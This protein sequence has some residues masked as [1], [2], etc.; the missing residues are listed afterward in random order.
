MGVL[1]PALQTGESIRTALAWGMRW[2]SPYVW[3][4]GVPSYVPGLE[5]TK[6]CYRF[7]CTIS[8]NAFEGE[9]LGTFMAGMVML[10]PVRGFTPLRGFKSRTLKVPKSDIRMRPFFAPSA[11]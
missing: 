3:D 4:K 11:S 7:F 5:R 9:N 1:P 2:E 8:F 6:N 10:F